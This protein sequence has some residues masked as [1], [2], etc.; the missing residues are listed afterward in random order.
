MLRLKLESELGIFAKTII[1]DLD[2]TYGLST[3]HD[4]L[5]FSR[6]FFIGNFKEL[7]LD[8]FNKQC[9]MVQWYG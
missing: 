5:E 4:L 6:H 9:L 2:L 7:E 1:K 3:R 8:S